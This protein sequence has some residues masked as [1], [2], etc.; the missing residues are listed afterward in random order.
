M[1]TVRWFLN[2][3]LIKGLQSQGDNKRP[4]AT[5]ALTLQAGWNQ[6]FFRGY[7][8]GY[9]PFRVGLILDGTPEKLWNVQLSATPP[10]STVP[11]AR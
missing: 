7:C 8:F 4:W 10:E 9:P 1:T 2:G 6:V 5:K 3:E 11:R